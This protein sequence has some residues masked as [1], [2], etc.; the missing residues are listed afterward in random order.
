[1]YAKTLVTIAVALIGA[2]SSSF[3][4]SSSAFASNVGEAAYDYPTSVAS[5]I[6]RSAVKEATSTARAAGQI[7]VGE[8]TVVAEVSNAG[9]SRAQVRAETLEA[10]RLG[11]IGRGE[12]N[13]IPTDA[14]QSL[15]RMAGLKAL[16]MTVASR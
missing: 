12:H 8:Q 10:I 15:V 2:A 4:S 6:S 9:L 11:L 7:V 16:S 13:V 1:M 14:Q 3:A 5:S